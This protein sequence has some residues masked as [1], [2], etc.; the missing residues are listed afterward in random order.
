[1]VI[2]SIF[3][4]FDFRLNLGSEF[5]YSNVSFNGFVRRRCKNSNDSRLIKTT[6][7]PVSTA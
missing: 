1:M 2:R 6:N 5:I 7:N 3:Q 4:Q